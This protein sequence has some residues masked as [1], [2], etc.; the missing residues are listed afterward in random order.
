MTV[1]RFLDRRQNGRRSLEE[2]N[3]CAVRRPNDR[4]ALMPTPMRP[5]RARGRPHCAAVPV[6]ATGEMCLLIS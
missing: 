4:N 2:L 5:T 6:V 3:K 1:Q